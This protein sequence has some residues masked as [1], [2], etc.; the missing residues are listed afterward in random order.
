MP[1][2]VKQI[3]TG[4]NRPV[5]ACSPPGDSSRL[6][7]LEQRGEIKILDL[8]A[9][10][11]LLKATP[12]LTLSSLATGN[13]QGLLGLAFHPQYATNRTFF[14]NYTEPGGA[15]IIARYTVKAATPDQ[16]DSSSAIVV[17]KVLQPFANHNGGWLGFGPDGFL[18]IGL[19]DGGAGND[20]GNRAQNLGELLGKMLRI[21]IDGD[22]FPEDTN[23][24]Y[25]IP[26][27][28]PFVNN[29]GSMKE[30]WAYGLRNPWRCSFDRT[31]GE[32]YIADVGQD[33]WEE[34]NVQPPGQGGQNYGWRLREGFH[35]TG[36][37]SASDVVLTDPVH[38]Y[39][40][41]EGIAIIG[42]YVYRGT[43]VPD[44]VGK[45]LFADFTGPIWM[46]SFADGKWA[47]GENIQST[48]FPDG[49]AP[50]SITSFGEDAN[51]ELYLLNQSPGTIYRFEQI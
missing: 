28:N 43:K 6:F 45:Y 5:F 46:L 37:G 27:T 19:G 34:V 44:L 36:L 4:L 35:D 1:V 32:L 40:H 7:I 18:Y 2:V 41:G 42:G 22:D 14:I 30:I 10:Q 50:K 9:S 20:P 25:A 49:N 38:E 51:G 21:D 24:K 8:T 26:S 16:A 23:K 29:S 15:T 11:P 12:F 39:D 47:V 33:D 17:M 13:E 3:V 31:S 48:L